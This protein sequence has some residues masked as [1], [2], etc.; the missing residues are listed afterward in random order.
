MD[1]GTA[2]ALPGKSIDFRRKQAFTE[3]A[4]RSRRSI[5]VKPPQFSLLGN[6]QDRSSIT[7]YDFFSIIRSLK[8]PIVHCVLPA[9]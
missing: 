5:R 8:F 4:T 2:T 7:N 9:S 3:D 6:V 1:D